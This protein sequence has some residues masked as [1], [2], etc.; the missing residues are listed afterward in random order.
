M[1]LFRH[2]FL[3]HHT[4]NHRAK[5][6]HPSGISL[7]IL[8]YIVFNLGLGLVSREHPSILGYASRIQPAEII[9]LTNEKRQAGG[10]AAL[11]M[12]SQLNQAA[13]GKASDMI[14]RNYWAHV[15]P[16]GTQPWAFVTDAGY[17]YRYAGENLA[18]DFSDPGG[19]VN[20]WMNSPSH[21]E[22]ILNPKYRDIGIAVV[23]GSLD[24][25]ETT[26]VV[27]MFGT[28]LSASAPSGRTA[29]FSVQ[30]AQTSSAPTPA[31]SPYP[32]P[33][34]EIYMAAA[35]SQTSPPSPFDYSRYFSL[36]LL[37]V[38]AAVLAADI[39]LVRKHHIVRWT[40]KSFAHLIFLIVLIIAVG[41]LLRGQIL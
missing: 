17:T 36:G 34:P 10:L 27:Q 6:L 14:A 28:R 9:R 1:S 32:T 30:A 37:G 8:V 13:A 11:N 3:P 40:S 7:A 35:V 12:D 38:L 19:V 15:S 18:R 4:N 33:T 20:A 26:L 41:T 5:I 24:G 2:L 25:R 21:R 31:P 39:L 29:S 23:D 16:V 22:N